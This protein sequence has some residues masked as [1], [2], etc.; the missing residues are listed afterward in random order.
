MI[1]LVAQMLKL[2]P[3]ERATIPEI[4]GHPWVRGT[5]SG[6]AP[7]DIAMVPVRDRCDDGEE[8][9]DFAITYSPT[10][11]ALPG[12]PSF[13]SPVE[14]STGGNDDKLPSIVAKSLSRIEIFGA[15]V[16]PTSSSVMPTAGSGGSGNALVPSGT[17]GTGRARPGRIMDNP[18]QSKLGNVKMDKHSPRPTPMGALVP[19]PKPSAAS[20]AATGASSGPGN[21]KR[22]PSSSTNSSSSSRGRPRQG[23]ANGSSG[24]KSHAE[25]AAAH[26]N[27]SEKLPIAHQKTTRRR[28]DQHGDLDGIESNARGSGHALDSIGAGGKKVTHTHASQHGELTSASPAAA[29]D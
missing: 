4:F 24:D 7:M 8:D 18:L 21:F 11:V 17:P 9:L 14:S 22:N 1:D 26:A 16:M 5:A 2:D 25:R 23:T 15:A 12:S 3:N 20:S 6:C 19:S 29:H 13:L 10:K 27:E 28:S